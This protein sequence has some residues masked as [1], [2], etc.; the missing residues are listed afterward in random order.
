MKCKNV[1]R[2]DRICRSCSWWNMKDKICEK[3][4]PFDDCERRKDK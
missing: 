1:Q 3:R 2:D 4:P